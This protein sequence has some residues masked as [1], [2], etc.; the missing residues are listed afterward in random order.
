MKGKKTGGRQKGVTNKL[1]ADVKEMVLAA[2]TGVGGQEYLELQAMRNP[3]AFMSLLGKIMP[4]QI[5]LNAKVS[6]TIITVVSFAD[7][8]Y[9]EEGNP[10]HGQTHD[11]STQQ[12]AH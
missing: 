7:L 3:Q 2:L 5:D 10:I 4:S 12:T 11:E 6:K 1:T 9:D 8:K